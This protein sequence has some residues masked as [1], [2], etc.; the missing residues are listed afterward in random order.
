MVRVNDPKVGPTFWAIILV[1]LN[2]LEK[3]FT[4]TPS[5]DIDLE[6]LQMRFQK[7]RSNFDII[8]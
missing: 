3:F 1:Y 2:I 8:W 5:Q 6:G 7:I 4:E